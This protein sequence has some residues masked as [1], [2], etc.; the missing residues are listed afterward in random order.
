MRCFFLCIII[1]FIGV[2]ATDANI[3]DPQMEACLCAY[4]TPEGSDPQCSPQIEDLEDCEY[5]T[6]HCEN[7]GISDLEGIQYAT[8]NYRGLEY[9]Y[10]SGNPIQSLTPISAHIHLYRLSFGGSTGDVSLDHIFALVDSIEEFIIDDS[11]VDVSYLT[12]FSKCNTIELYSVNETFDPEVLS[13]FPNL[14]SLLLGIVSM[15]SFSPLSQL[16]NLTQL[17]LGG[18]NGVGYWYGD[19]S[20]L[21][22]TIESIEFNHTTYSNVLD[23]IQDFEGL[24][25]FYFIGDSNNFSFDGLSSEV[26][27]N[28]RDIEITLTSPGNHNILDL[29]GFS[30][31]NSFVCSNCGLHSLLI[32]P[33]NLRFLDLSFNPNFNFVNF[34]DEYTDDLQLATFYAVGSNVSTQDLSIW[35][36]SSHFDFL[37]TCDQTSPCASSSGKNLPSFDE[38]EI[39]FQHRNGK[40]KVEC[41][42]GYYMDIWSMKC[43]QDEGTTCSGCMNDGNLCTGSFFGNTPQ[44]VHSR[45][46]ISYFWFIGFGIFV[47]F[48]VIIGV[49]IGIVLHFKSQQ[50]KEE[51]EDLLSAS[52]A[53][54]EQEVDSQPPPEINDSLCTWLYNTQRENPGLYNSVVLV[55]LSA[56]SI[57]ST[58]ISPSAINKALSKQWLSAPLAETIS[59][60]SMSMNPLFSTISGARVT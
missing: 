25:N 41:A 56:D 26:F 34:F 31:L 40:W 7:Y 46:R 1:V 45:V 50:T 21:P 8:M 55:R 38:N 44:C 53:S 15:D 47:I 9:I 35:A 60:S 28:L 18:D 13:T 58:L 23:Q 36:S 24:S 2:F 52:D 10:I 42:Y 29:S 37:R 22:S 20:D 14:K 12:Q 43:V 6:L 30:K 48:G 57:S 3:P 4:L 17:Y 16:E 11:K 51:Q 59:K 32:D 39:C 19:L 27:P 49:V 54:N 33:E 5:N